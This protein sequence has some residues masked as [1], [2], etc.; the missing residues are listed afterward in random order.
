MGGACDFCT[1]KRFGVTKA[2]ERLGVPVVG[3]E[4]EHHTVADP[5]AEGY[6]VFTF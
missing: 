3:G 5:V 4:G 1:T 2:A 6:T